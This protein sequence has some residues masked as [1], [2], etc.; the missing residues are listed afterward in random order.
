MDGWMDLEVTSHPVALLSGRLNNCEGSPF[1]AGSVSLLLPRNGAPACCWQR[2][3]VVLQIIGY[4]VSLSAAVGGNGGKQLLHFP[5]RSPST[6]LSNS[7]WLWE[8]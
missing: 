3:A 8:N 7:P 6:S 2:A 5:K 1:S 4:I